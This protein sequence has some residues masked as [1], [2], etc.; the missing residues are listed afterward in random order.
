[1]EIISAQKGYQTKVLSSSA[2]IVISGGAAGLGKTFALLLEFTRHIYNK[3]WGGVIFRRTTPQITN[4]GGLW[5]ASYQ[6]Y[7]YIGA[8]PR[9]SRHEWRFKSGCKLK[10]AHLEYEKNKLDWLGAEIPFIGFD[11]LT[12]FT[13][14]QFFYLLTRNRSTCGITPYVRATCNPDPDSWVAE[15]INWWI[16]PDT[17]LPIPEREGVIRYFIKHKGKYIWGDTKAE[18]IDKASFV[19]DEMIDKSKGVV[20]SEDFVKSITFIS[21][22]IYDNKKLLEKNPEYLANLMSQDEDTRKQLLEGSWVISLSENDVYEYQAFKDMFTNDFVRRTGQRYI[23]ADVAMDGSDKFILGVWDGFVLI[24]IEVYDKSGGKSIPN[25]IK[26]LKKTYLVPERN[27]CYD[28]DGVGGF[29]KE[30]FPNAHGFHNG[31]IPYKVDGVKENY[32]NLKTQCYYKSGERVSDNGYYVMPEVAQKSY[33]DQRTIQQRFM[34]ERKAIKKDLERDGK[35]RIISK[36]EMKALLENESP[37]IMDMFMM[38][39][40]FELKPKAKPPKSR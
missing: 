39:E 8:T 6:I 14:S 11:E 10:F 18:V 4:E 35:K 37:D 40:V 28:Q 9:D 21:G 23:T 15:F 24:D 22:S 5:D 20:Q 33:D 25:A 38:R 1:M 29:L 16:D 31:G 26:K 19:L 27:V 12:H 32:A 30:I 3:K 17:G 2:D 13:E 36:K 34:W 7:P